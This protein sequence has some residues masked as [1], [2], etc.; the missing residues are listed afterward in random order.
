[1]PPAA[2]PSPAPSPLAPCGAGDSLLRHSSAEVREAYARWQT[3]GDSAAADAIVA[4][5]V[6]DHVPDKAR[7]ASLILDD[8][9]A[10][11][12][13]LGFDSMA[14]T[15]MVF[16][17]EDLFQV[18]ITNSEIVGLRTLGDLRAFVRHRLAAPA[19]AGAAARP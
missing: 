15:E 12:A 7:R 2:S 10:L 8:R 11:A 6:R 4:A 18:T 14:L 1:M 9:Q 16:A 17:F 19:P 5:V 3:A 13:D